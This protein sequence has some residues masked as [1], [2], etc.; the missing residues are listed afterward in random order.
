MEQMV[1]YPWPGNVRELESF[2]QR[3]LILNSGSVLETTEVLHVGVPR[4]LSD[5]SNLKPIVVDL[6]EAERS[7]IE[8]VLVGSRWVIGGEDGA[9]DKLGVPPSTLRSKM[10]KLGISRPT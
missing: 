9:A 5:L 7:H 2:I 6:H 3:A 4:P 1:A 10:K 8:N